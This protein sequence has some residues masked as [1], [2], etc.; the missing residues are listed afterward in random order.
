MEV[1]NQCICNVDANNITNIQTL[2]KCDWKKLYYLSLHENR[3]IEGRKLSEMSLQI[4][5]LNMEYNA[6]EQPQC[7][8]FRWIM[9][10]NFP[11]NF[12]LRKLIINV[13]ICSMK[14][15]QDR[16]MG[17]KFTMKKYNAC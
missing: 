7:E 13:E 8:D 14:R 1:E 17:E 9:K 3:I 4:E 2:R 16:F 10:M 6:D 5:T 15:I 11:V 12:N